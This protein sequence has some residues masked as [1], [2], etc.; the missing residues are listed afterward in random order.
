MSQWFTSLPDG[1][2]SAVSCDVKLDMKHTRTSICGK[3]RDDWG[4]ESVLNMILKGTRGTKKSVFTSEGA[5][6][7]SIMKSASFHYRSGT[8]GGTH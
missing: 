4:P 8:A 3:S 2:D 5:H 7:L 1:R 6:L